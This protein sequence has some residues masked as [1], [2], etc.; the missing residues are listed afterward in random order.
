MNSFFSFRDPWQNVNNA[1]VENDR[2]ALFLVMSAVSLLSLYHIFYNCPRIYFIDDCTNSLIRLILQQKKLLLTE[3]IMEIEFQTLINY[4]NTACMYWKE[5][6]TQEQQLIWN[7]LLKHK[8]VNKILTNH[9]ILDKSML[10]D[11]L[12][13]RNS[14]I[15][16]LI[17]ASL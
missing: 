3:N 12:V 10:A 11:F 4:N 9:I 13:K 8:E 14:A 17:K 16:F 1:D 7:N 6:T 5:A 2:F 15:K